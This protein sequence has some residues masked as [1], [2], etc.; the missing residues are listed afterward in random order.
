MKIAVVHYH[1]RRG[2]V[3]RVIETALESLG[4]AA[5]VAVLSGEP[6]GDASPLASRSRV[7]PGLGYRDEADDSDSLVHALR[8]AAI[9]A[10]GTTPDLWHF[11]NHSLGKN[12]AMPSVIHRLAADGARMLLQVHDFAEDG[13]PENFRRQRA[14]ADPDKLTWYPEAPQIHYAT[15]NRR[16]AGFLAGAGLSGDRLHLLPNAVAPPPCDT[17]ARPPDFVKPGQRFLL[18]PTRGIRRKNLGEML[19]LAALT[20]DEF[21]YASTLAPENPEWLA[22]HDRWETFAARHRLPARLGIGADPAVSFGGLLGAADALLT[23]SV[24]EGFGLAF[25]EPWLI[26]KTVRGRDLPE[27]TADFTESGIRLEGLYRRLEVPES[28]IDTRRFRERIDAGLTRAFASYGRT[29]PPASGERALAAASRDGRVDFGRLDEPLQE[30]AIE[31][32]LANPRRAGELIEVPPLSPCAPELGEAN[33]RAVR[34]THGVAAYG[35]RLESIY[36]EILASPTA[37][38]GAL[39]GGRLLDAYLDPARFSLLRN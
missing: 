31:W 32:V 10:L 5:E 8:E 15:L 34:E 14:A 30:Q 36:R 12:V 27:I 11:H 17:G 2:G 19:L 16:D 20:G 25:L 9:D 24:A 23:T 1:L 29:L 21:S 37:E 22:I 33:A 4:P 28:A 38:P 3:T 35:E 26:G 18:Y 7:V 6:P 13:R 39:D